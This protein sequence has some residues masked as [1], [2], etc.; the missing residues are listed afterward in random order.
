MFVMRVQRP[1]ADARNADIPD[2]VDSALVMLC[3]E[4][5]VSVLVSAG[6]DMDAA[7][8]AVLSASAAS[9]PHTP[10]I[11]VL[12]VKVTIV[13]GPVELRTPFGTQ[14]GTSLSTPHMP[15]NPCIPLTPCTAG[16]GDHCGRAS[17]AEDP[18]WHAARHH[19]AHGQAWCASPGR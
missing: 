14:P 18:P 10:I 19:A 8:A 16:Q 5:A 17:G 4:G 6:V 2:L 13:D 9:Q 1:I 11:H 3:S 15:F 12:Q 7:A